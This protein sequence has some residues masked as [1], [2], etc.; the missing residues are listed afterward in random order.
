MPYCG[1][2]GAELIPNA[3]FCGNCG[4]TQQPQPQQAQPSQPCVN[5]N[6]AA[7]PFPPPPPP[8]D[9]NQFST[10]VPVCT[11]TQ[12]ACGETV[13]GAIFLRRMKSFGRYDS[14][15]GVVTSQRLIFA[16]M[17][18]KMLTDAAM[19]ARDKAKA[20]GKGFF[21][22]WDEQLRATFS[23]TQKYLNMTPSDIIAETP[24]N[25]AIDN[26]AISE[27]KLS[28]KDINKGHETHSHEF[29][30]HVVFAQGQYV[31]RI[32]KRDETVNLLRQVYGERVKLPFGYSSHGVNIRIGL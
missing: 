32:D 1:N 17:T 19:Q 4:M 9:L 29:E 7:A 18:S 21:G 16:Q 3:K 26:G 14:F 15:S 25:F 31:F 30:I 22:Q 27:V 13:V 23:Y 11:P 8:S 28:L 10:E 20:E 12:Q 6:L 2:C 5:P 24:G